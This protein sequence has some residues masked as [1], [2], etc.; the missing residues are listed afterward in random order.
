MLIV[1]DRYVLLVGMEQGTPANAECWGTSTNFGIINRGRFVV[2]LSLSLIVR[3]V[4]ASI[5][6][7]VGAEGKNTFV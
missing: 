1:V 2:L 3:F 7:G 6:S 4:L 5:C